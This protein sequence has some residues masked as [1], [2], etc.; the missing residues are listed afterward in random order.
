MLKVVHKAMNEAVLSIPNRRE[1]MSKVLLSR[2]F[3]NY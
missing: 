2:C 3:A 1:D